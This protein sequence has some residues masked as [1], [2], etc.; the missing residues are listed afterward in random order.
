MH[1]TRKCSPHLALV[2]AD[3]TEVVGVFVSGV[4]GPRYFAELCLIATNLRW[5]VIVLKRD[6]SREEMAR[7]DVVAEDSSNPS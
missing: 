6:C 7:Q 4:S 1:V 3:F 2:T 5:P